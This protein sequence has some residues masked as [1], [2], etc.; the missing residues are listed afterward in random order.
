MHR[1][2]ARFGE[3]VSSVHTPSWAD[4]IT[5][6]PAFKL[7]VHTGG[8][9]DGDD[10]IEKDVETHAP[11]NSTP[12]LPR[13]PPTALACRA[14]RHG[15]T[16]LHRRASPWRARLPTLDRT[17]SSESLSPECR[18]FSQCARG[19]LSPSASA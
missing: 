13:F 7:S 18:P 17:A 12:P 19:R 14:S 6:T 10:V 2:L 16:R 9:Q 4:F 8:A 15:R 3:P 5:A 11:D 1:F